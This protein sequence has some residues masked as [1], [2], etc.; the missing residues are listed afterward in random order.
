MAVTLKPS[1]GKST[2]INTALTVP[3][4]I[5]GCG[6][7]PQVSVEEVLL[8]SKKVYKW[9]VETTQITPSLTIPFDQKDLA[10]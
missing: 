6:L 9:T 10:Q 1:V 3:L 8:T 7:V 2:S 5:M 4:T